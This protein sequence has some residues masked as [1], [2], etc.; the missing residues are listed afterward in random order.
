MTLTVGDI[1][2]VQLSRFEENTFHWAI[3][4]PLDDKR[5]AKYHA[6]GASGH[7]WFEAKP[8]PIEHNLEAL[9]TISSAVKIGSIKPEDATVNVF[10]DLF[11]TIPMEVPDVDKP[12][13]PEFTCLV[14]FREAIRRLHAAKVINCPNVDD[15]EAECESYAKTNWAGTD[16]YKG[17]MYYVSKFST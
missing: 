13:E 14:W 7:W 17:Y 4:V 11:E 6:K 8:V 5:A 15:L 1:L 12:R 10:L 9:D 3:C 2:A 16:G